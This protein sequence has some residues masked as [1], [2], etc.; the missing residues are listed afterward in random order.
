MFVGEVIFL[1]L[2]NM[3]FLKYADVCNVCI[4]LYNKIGASLTDQMN[5]NTS[6]RVTRERN[7]KNGANKVILCLKEHPYMSGEILLTKRELYIRIK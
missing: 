5:K 1:N 7:R 3:F 6:K 2:F 4:F